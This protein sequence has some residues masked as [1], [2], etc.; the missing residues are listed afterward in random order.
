MMRLLIAGGATMAPWWSDV[1][2]HHTRLQQTYIK[3][4]MSMTAN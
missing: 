2:N 4:L 1:D 3:M